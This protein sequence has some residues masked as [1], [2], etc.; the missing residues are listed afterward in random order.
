MFITPN[1]FDIDPDARFMEMEHCFNL[2]TEDAD[3]GRP[4]RPLDNEVF[5]DIYGDAPIGDG[6]QAT[7][8]KAYHNGYETQV[9]KSK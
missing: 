4:N 9:R 1:A 5:A 6:Y 2:G 3:A 8:P 7:M